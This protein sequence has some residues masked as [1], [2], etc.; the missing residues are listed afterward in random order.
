MKTQETI[1]KAAAN[2]RRVEDARRTESRSATG[3]QRERER[4]KQKTACI[5]LP[6]RSAKHGKCALITAK[7]TGKASARIRLHAKEMN[8]NVRWAAKL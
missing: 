4:E 1:V 8:R 5:V 6:C 3:E 2:R 7:V